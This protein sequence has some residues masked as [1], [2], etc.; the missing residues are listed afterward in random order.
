MLGGYFKSLLKLH[1][2]TYRHIFGNCALC[3][4]QKH[5]RGEWIGIHF[6]QHPTG[7]L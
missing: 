3:S 7:A 5:G 6:R 4:R 1:L 2:L